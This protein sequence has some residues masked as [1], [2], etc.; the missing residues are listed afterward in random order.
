MQDS[1]PTRGSFVHNCRFRKEFLAQFLE[2][3]AM[4]LRIAGPLATEDLVISATEDTSPPKWHLAHT[5]WFFE[6][7]ILRRFVPG[8]QE[9]DPNFDFLFNSYYETV[10][11]FLPKK[12]RSHLS[13]PS[14]D[15]ILAYRR[16]VDQAIENFVHEGISFE[17][18]LPILQL[19][20]HHEQQHQELLLMDIKRNFFANP[21]FPVYRPTKA[22]EQKQLSP[23]F[24]KFQGGLQEIG[25]RG[26]GFAYDNE[27]G[28][29]KV[30]LE[31]FSLGNGLVTNGE[32][33]EFIE[34]GGYENP[35]LWL[36]DGWA[37][38]KAECWQAPLYWKKVKGQWKE[39][40]LAGLA[41]LD[42]ARP[43]SHISYFEALAY[44]HFRS[45]RLPTEFEWE[46]AASQS[47]V[48]GPFLDEGCLIPQNSGSLGGVHGS[49]WQWTQSA[50]LPY[51]RYQPFAQELAEY[52]GKFM[53][54]QMVL[55]GGSFGT[56]LSHYRP[57]YRNFYY[58]HMRW[59]F[60][61][62]RLARDE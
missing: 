31:P 44:A 16:A 39:Y 46:H 61:G 18:A 14:S 25:F 26:D 54:N 3:R 36:S 23:G 9:F 15:S 17:E 57:T 41:T 27:L 2:I 55:R 21:I 24:V 49:L 37:A 5:T 50:Y 47:D 48:T 51:P 34:E 20:L 22:E 60:C 6:R 32:F 28:R 59:Q 43:V 19:G 10:G 7:M 4:T 12:S 42:P 58:P 1:L 52:N 30:W 11:A 8:Y 29:H 45:A 13:R 62:L 35:R 33:L 53:C 56:P 38:K 40:S